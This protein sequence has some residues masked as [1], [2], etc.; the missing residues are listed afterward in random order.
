M[1]DL[2][3]FQKAFDTVWRS[4]LYQKL[5]NLGIGG[6]FYKVV[7]C[8]YSNSKFAVENDNFMSKPGDYNK[9]VRQGYGLSPLLFT[10]YINDVDQI[11]YTSSSDPVVLD[12]TKLNCLIYAADLLLFS[13]TQEGLQSCLDSLQLYCDSWKLKIN[14]DKTE[15]MILVVVK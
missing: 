3:T 10:I 7:K 2:L 6:N 5:L 15:V 8:M 9:G 12:S 13:E 1:H 14:I 4:G 11:F